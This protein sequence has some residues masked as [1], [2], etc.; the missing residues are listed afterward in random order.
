MYRDLLAVPIA[1]PV[2]S[3]P[4]KMYVF[5]LYSGQLCLLEHAVLEHR[6][7]ARASVC[8]CTYIIVVICLSLVDSHCHSNVLV[9]CGYKSGVSWPVQ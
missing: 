4:L 6:Q 5:G 2:I 7:K 9:R 3:V 1:K 8:S